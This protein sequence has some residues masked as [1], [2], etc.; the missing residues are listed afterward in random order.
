MTVFFVFVLKPE[1]CDWFEER[2]A[3]DAD[4]LA[5]DAVE[6]GRDVIA[7]P[8]AVETTVTTATD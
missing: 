4:E 2:D 1:D 6:D 5:D 3:A 7:L 8:S